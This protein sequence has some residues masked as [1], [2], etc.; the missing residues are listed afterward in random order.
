MFDSLQPH[1][2]SYTRLPCLGRLHCL[3]EFAQIHVHWVDDAIYILYAVGPTP[4]PRSCGC[5]GAGG[6]RGSIPRW[7]SGRAVVRRYPSSKVRSN[8]CALLEQP[9]RDTFHAK[10]GSLK[11]RNGM[12]VTEAED[13]KKRWQE[14]T[15]ELYKEDLTTQMITMVWSLT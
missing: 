1:G 8:G 9:W 11:D 4:C 14:Y 7:R 13:I 10:M 6:P 5:A 12:D 3:P 2:L 15:E